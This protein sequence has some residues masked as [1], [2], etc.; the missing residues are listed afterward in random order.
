MR[1]ERGGSTLARLNSSRLLYILSIS[2]TL[3][4]AIASARATGGRVFVWGNNQSGQCN[5]PANAT[6]II[7]IA[8]GSMHTLALTEDHRLLAWGDGGVIPPPGVSNLVSIAAGGFHSIGIRPDG[9]LWVWSPQPPVMN[10]PA[11]ATNLIKVAAGN[12]HV[13]ALRN[14]GRVFAWGEDFWGATNVPVGATNIVD[15]AA[16]GTFSVGLRR[17]GKVLVWGLPGQLVLDVTNVVA[18][19]ASYDSAFALESDGRVAVWNTDSGLSNVV[20]IAGGLSLHSDGTVTGA[21]VPGGLSNV[22]AI[23]SGSQNGVVIQNFSGLQIQTQPRD[24]VV[25]AGD[26]AVF[27][28]SALGSMPLIYS[29]TKDGSPIAEATG[30]NLFLLNAQASDIG[31]YQVTVTNQTGTVTSQPAALTVISS[32]PRIDILITNLLRYPGDSGVLE[33]RVRGTAPIGSIWQKNSVDIPNATNLTLSFSNLTWDDRASYQL[34]ATNS[35]GTSTSAPV[36]IILLEAIEWG[37]A[38]TVSEQATNLVN[39]VTGPSHALALGENGKVIAWGDNT[40]GQTS[41]PDSATNI[42]AIAGGQTFSLALASNGIPIAW[43][44]NSVP[45]FATNIVAISAGW[46][47]ALGLRSDGKVVAWGNNFYGQATVPPD[48]TNIVSVAG[49][50]NHSLALRSDGSVLAWGINS[51]GQT[52]IPA[53]AFNIMAVAA[54]ANHNLALKSDGTAV[55]WGDN[56]SGQCIIPVNASNLIAVAAGGNSSLAL[57]KDG[58]VI[59]WGDNSYSQTIIPPLATNV[60]AIAAAANFNAALLNRG[61]L[62][63]YQPPM[64]QVVGAGDSLL[65]R[66]S[67]VGPQ[68]LHYQWFFE[69]VAIAGATN[70]WVLLPDLQ[71]TTAGNYTVAVTSGLLSQTSQVATVTVIPR[72]PIIIQQTSNSVGLPGGSVTLEVSAIGTE[73]M[74]FQWTFG[75][76]NLLFATNGTL[77]LTNLKF[78]DAGN[79]QLILSNAVGMVTSSVTRLDIFPFNLLTAFTNATGSWSGAWGDFDNDGRLDLLVSGTPKGNQSITT[80]RL[81]RNLG[82][83]SFVETNVGLSQPSISATW[84]DFDNDGLLDVVLSTFG[85]ASIYHNTGQGS[86]TNLNISL[87]GDLGASA[88]V[89]DFDND[90]K[91]DI[92]IGGHMYRNLGGNKFTSVNVGLPSIQYGSTA[93]GDYD[94]DGR[95]DLLVCG[96]FTSAAKVQLFRN[97]GNGTFTNVNV[98]FTNLYRGSVAWIDFEG[99]GKL[100]ALVSGQTGPGVPVIALYRNNGDGT[101]TSVSNGL[102]AFSFTSLAA[103]DFDN[104]GQPDLFHSGNNGSTYTANIYHGSPTGLFTPIITGMPTNLAPVGSWGDYD[105]DGR[106]DLAMSTSI[107]GQ[108]VVGIYRNDSPATNTPPTP[109][110]NLAADAGPNA[111][112]FSWS[113]GSDGQTASNALTY[114]LRIGRTPGGTDVLAPNSDASGIRHLAAPGNSGETTTCFLTNLTFGQYYWSVQTVDSGFEGS[115]FPPEA[116]FVYACFTQPPTNITASQAT[117]IG[118]M[119]ANGFPTT[120]YFEWGAGTNFNN[121]TPDQIIGAGATNA[122]VSASLAGL[123]PGGNYVCRLAVSNQLGRATGGTQSFTTLNIPQIIPQIVTSLSATGATLNASVTPEGS[124]TT[125]YFEYGLSSAYGNASTT[126]NIGNGWSPV[127]VSRTITGLIGGQIYHYHVV[128]SNA[129]GVAYSAD[130]TFATTTEPEVATLAATN[131]GPV[132]ATLNASVR[133]NTLSTIA[134]FEY[135]LTTNY[136][137]TTAPQGLGNSTN[138]VSVGIT[139]SNLIRVTTYHFRA[140]ATNATALIYGADRSFLTT[141][142]VIA[143]PATGLGMT[144]ATLNG[145]VNPNGFLTSVVFDYGSTTNYGTTSPVISL[146]ATNGLAA[147]SYDLVGLAS[148]TTYYFRVRATNDDGVRQSGGLS[149]QALPQFSVLPSGLSGSIGGSIAW[150]D[151]YNDGKLDMLVCDSTSTRIYHN[152][153]GGSFVVSNTAIPAVT[154]GSVVCGDFNNDGWLDVLVTGTVAGNPVTR[155]YRNTGNGTFTNQNATLP[156]IAFRTIQWGDFDNDG[157]PDVLLVGETNSVGLSL[158]YHNNGDGTFQDSHATLPAFLDATA[159]SADY[160]NDGRLD[161]LLTG[162]LG[163]WYSNVFTQI[164]HNDGSNNFHQA[165]ITFDGV[166]GGYAD[167]ADLDGDG[168]LDL[169]VGGNGTGLGPILRLY[170]NN[171]DGTFTNLTSTL[172]Q[173]APDAV[174]W[175]DFDNDGRP[176]VLIRGQQFISSQVPSNS[177]SGVLHNNGDGTFTA[178]NF[179]LPELWSSAGGWADYDNNGRLD[180]VI[181]GNSRTGAQML[182]YRNNNPGSN[183]PPGNPINL[184]STVSTNSVVLTWQK[185]TDLPVPAE[186]LTYNVRVGLTPGGGEILSA[187]S[188]SNGWRRLVKMGNAGTALV[189]SLNNLAPGTYYWS[190]QA[191]GAAFGGS[192]FATNATF[193]IL[194]SPIAIPDSISTLTNTPVSFPASKLVTND[195]DLAGLP[196]TVVSVA[197]NSSHGGQISLTAGSITYTPPANFNGNDIFQYTVSNGQTPTTTG[198]VIATVGTGGI[199]PLNVISGPTTDHGDFVM[200]VGGVPGLTYTVEAAPRLSGPW[201]KVFNIVAPINDQGLGIGGFEIRESLSTNGYRFYRIIY[202]PY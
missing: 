1:S 41:I 108:T 173:F 201:D 3:L 52:N 43:G 152:L 164:F 115:P 65:L 4:L 125:V 165:A 85:G 167:W 69:G 166:R 59:G 97:L 7:A 53:S 179:P 182:F 163:I 17:D 148:G 200:R 140:V 185:P 181:S 73:P 98:G 159:A 66:A 72:A 44:Y 67:A 64:S 89:G 33:A 117:F 14:D 49:G 76:T 145:L 10:Y 27:S 56:S 99:D 154:G 24:A 133:P 102:P 186:A 127:S 202:P 16:G 80:T 153:G 177:Y 195:I 193:T 6:N 18:I 146:A 50:A 35:V 196:L 155:I 151:F 176:D 92:L 121:R 2:F 8:E 144:N 178:Q 113:A 172:P 55:A 180:A 81:F 34:V 120:A 128:A 90:G 114:N 93:W 122:T 138:L 150:G 126:T 112:H 75:G 149:F 84:G 156:S 40:W 187:S 158:I 119:T 118:V 11:D 79:Y 170:R 71:Q 194:H 62:K 82:N 169:I 139:V 39:I 48:A 28:C 168:W 100:D 83:G 110:L 61:A 74:T 142:D 111:I 58:L 78:G 160:D 123:L 104:D 96:L 175:G 68:P 199:A 45:D 91:L 87:S 188:A 26:P 47:H 9:S 5:V 60:V 13:M 29:W 63:I 135:G 19:T 32:A 183:S 106:L 174:L 134:Y 94:N 129:V 130:L 198:T 184:S 161:V 36:S 15:I 132:S 12:L 31:T 109:P 46:T 77:S 147:I 20:A 141:N 103:G 131:I 171:H 107:N 86:F 57:R 190:V 23:A 88:T 192:L 143:L 105:G 54:G 124:P 157:R 22:T 42:V 51:S 116:S 95:P 38:S 191:V 137:N 197:T 37:G 101:F 70:T 25:L 162:R 136:G 30:P 21:D 189:L